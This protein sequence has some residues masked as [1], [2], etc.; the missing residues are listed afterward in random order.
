MKQKIYIIG[1]VTVITVFTGAIF[2]VNHYPGA[3]VL[4]TAGM[5][6]LIFLFLPLAFLNH[7]RSDESRKSPALHIVAYITCLVVFTAMLFKLMHWP[8]AGTLLIIGLPFPYVVF[9]PVFIYVTSKDRNF[10][11]YNTVFVLLLLA[12]NSVFSG[13]LALNVTSD[14]VKDSYQLSRN[15]NN[16]EIVLAR[17]TETDQTSVVNAKIDEV[18]KLVNDCQSIVLTLDGKTR[19]QWNNDPGNLVRPDF[20]GSALNSMSENDLQSARKLYRGMKELIELMEITPGYESL[21]KNAK[22][23]FIFDK[24]ITEEDWTAEIFND[25]LAW[26]I[27]YLDGLQAN[28]LTIKATGTL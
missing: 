7:Y 2:K 9:L 4:I 27:I 19:E 22:G 14:R 8:F 12:L 16:Q 5:I 28:L 10:N 11:I 26:A 15:Y 24:S 18:I 21:A 25:F 3:G 1:V 20:R 17:L 6:A 23:I 13:L